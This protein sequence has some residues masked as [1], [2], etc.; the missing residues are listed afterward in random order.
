MPFSEDTPQRLIA[1]V[2]PNLL[3]K[4]GDYKPEDIAGG[5]EVIAAGGEVKVLNFEEGCSTTEI[6]EAI[7]GGRG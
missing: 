6:I 7:K 3:V 5:K 4:G 2:L 1:A